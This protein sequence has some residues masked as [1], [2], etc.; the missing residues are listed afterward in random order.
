MEFAKYSQCWLTE[1]DSIL[2][3]SAVPMTVSSSELLNALPLKLYPAVICWPHH[4]TPQ[5][6]LLICIDPKHV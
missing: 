4:I 3:T 1:E 5:G 6:R 2:I